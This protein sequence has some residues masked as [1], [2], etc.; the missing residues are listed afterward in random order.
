LSGTGG[1]G[2]GR[3]ELWQVLDEVLDELVVEATLGGGNEEGAADG[4]GDCDEILL[5]LRS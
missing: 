5:A 3:V 2:E 1:Q 4:E